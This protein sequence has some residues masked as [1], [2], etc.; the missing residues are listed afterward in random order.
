MGSRAGVVREM[1]VSQDLLDHEVP[2]QTWPRRRKS[3]LVVRP[4]GQYGMYGQRSPSVPRQP[5][6]PAGPVQI[7][8]IRTP[9]PPG[10]PGPDSMWPRRRK[11]DLMIYQ[12]TRNVKKSDPDLF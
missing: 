8:I 5:P 6:P 9:T 12:T 10:K 3:D 7:K 1:T 4:G 2:D 11:S